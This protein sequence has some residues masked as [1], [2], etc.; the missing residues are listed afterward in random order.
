M[1]DSCRDIAR[2]YLVGWQAHC[3][4]YPR[5]AGIR[6]GVSVRSEGWLDTQ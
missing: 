3:H 6:V 4:C 5:L 1:R 2:L